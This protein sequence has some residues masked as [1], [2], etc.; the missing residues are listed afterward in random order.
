[1]KSFFIGGK[2]QLAVMRLPL[3]GSHHHIIQQFC[4][5]STRAPPSANLHSRHAFL[6]GSAVEVELQIPHRKHQLYPRSYAHRKMFCEAEERLPDGLLA[7]P[8]SFHRG[9]IAEV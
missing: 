4:Q 6:L 7:L 1:M 3:Q 8:E 2:Q 5:F 9:Q